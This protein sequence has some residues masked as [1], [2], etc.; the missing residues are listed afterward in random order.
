MNEI[1]TT[2]ETKLVEEEIE[3]PPKDKSGF[4]WF[5][6]LNFILIITLAAAAWYFWDQDQKQS[7]V[8][9]AEQ[10]ATL[11]QIN[12]QLAQKANV[13]AINTH[14]AQ[15][16]QNLGQ[17][18]QRISDLQ[19]HNETLQA[20]TEKLFELYGRDK[21][22]WKLAEVEYLLRISQQK[23]ILE[24]DFEGSALTLQAASNKLAEAAD[25]GMLPVRVQISDE[26]AVLKTRSR[27]DLVGMT[28]LLS[29][30][31]KQIHSLTPGYQ[32]RS[33][34]LLSEQTKKQ[35]VAT[36]PLNQ[37]YQQKLNSFVQSLF[38]LK[39]QNVEITARENTTAIDVTQTLSDNLQL[40]RWSLLERD[41]FQYDK[42][43]VVNVQLFEEYYDLENAAN[44]DFYDSLK[45]LQKSSIKVEKP[46]ISQSLQMLKKIISKREN[47]ASEPVPEVNQE[48]EIPV[49]P[50]PKSE[51]NQE[52]ASEEKSDV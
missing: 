17:S 12:S 37:T 33:A 31:E 38:T 26:I 25:P 9:A 27:P 48:V 40:T 15:L 43:M 21:D 50:E 7:Q 5:S 32:T 51:T 20:S 28:L 4:P 41:A 24:N 2:S 6:L 29:R 44:N 30:L 8:M 18:N 22:T 1:E 49:K 52:Q 34:L 16:E 42:L 11:A 10:A 36:Q 39:K 3:T 35:E 46:D 23:L 13:A 14:L 47:K 45:N 19:Q